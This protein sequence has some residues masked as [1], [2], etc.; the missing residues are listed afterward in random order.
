M[1][2]I[3]FG[4]ENLRHK[5]FRIKRMKWAAKRIIIELHVNRSVFTKGVSPGHY[6]CLI[7]NLPKSAVLEEL[8]ATVI[9]IR[10]EFPGTYVPSN[11]VINSSPKVVLFGNVVLTSVKPRLSFTCT[12]TVFVADV[13]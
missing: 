8:T 11:P 2:D 9:I 6:I 13:V 7:W 3:G 12:F 4:C 10:I 5:I 1:R